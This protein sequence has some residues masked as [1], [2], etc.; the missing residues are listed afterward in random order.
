MD[1]DNAHPINLDDCPLVAKAESDAGDS[2]G[3]GNSTWCAWQG[4]RFIWLTHYYCTGREVDGR[5]HS[6]TKLYGRFV[7]C[8]DLQ[9][10]LLNLRTTW[11]TNEFLSQLG[12]KGSLS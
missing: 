6:E 8:N 5:I 10:H 1:F 2:P 7:D 12:Y 4:K 3:I 9:E 11:W